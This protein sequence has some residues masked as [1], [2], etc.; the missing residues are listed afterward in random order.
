M[1]LTINETGTVLTVTIEEVTMPA[2]N[3]FEKVNDWVHNIHV[4]FEEL[5]AQCLGSAT[6]NDRLKKLLIDIKSWDVNE[7]LL[8]PPEIR[9]RIQAEIEK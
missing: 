5:Q 6:E 9:K 7:Y 1:S 8:I 4:S 2:N 3:C